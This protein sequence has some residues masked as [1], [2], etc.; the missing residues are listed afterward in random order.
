MT[1]IAYTSSIISKRFSEP[2]FRRKQCKF[3]AK[4]RLQI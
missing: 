4:S 2:L 1:V 3:K